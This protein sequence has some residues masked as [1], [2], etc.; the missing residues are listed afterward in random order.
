MAIIRLMLPLF[1]Q[2]ISSSPRA[3]GDNSPLHHPPRRTETPC[4]AMAPSQGED[5]H[6]DAESQA[7][8]AG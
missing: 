5:R 3:A 6:G 7:A 8:G 1:W 2:L 4:P